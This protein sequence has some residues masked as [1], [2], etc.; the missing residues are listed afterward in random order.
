VRLITTTKWLDV[1][2][3]HMTFQCPTQAAWR[4][5]P[6]MLPQVLPSLMVL[7]R[8]TKVLGI[9]GSVELLLGSVVHVVLS[10]RVMCQLVHVHTIRQ[11]LRGSTYVSYR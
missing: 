5:E 3:D 7:R 4:E 10:L 9:E 2:P 8:L 6:L 1:T 11:L